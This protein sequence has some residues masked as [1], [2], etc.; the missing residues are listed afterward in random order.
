M[1]RCDYHT[2]T[3]LC[4]H[5][6]GEPEAFVQRALELGL[7]EYGIADHAPT[8][9]YYDDWRMLREELPAYISWVERA[10]A[11]A[12]GSD[13]RIRV[14]LECDWL[15]GCESWIEELSG[16]YNWDYLIGSIHYISTDDSF[17]NPIYSQ[18]ASIGKNN[19]EDWHNYWQ[20][21]GD[22]VKSGLFDF[23]GHLDIIKIWGHYPEGD[24]MPYYAPVLD[25]LQA[26][27][28]AVEL[29]VA[30]WLK[31][32]AEQ[33]P[34]EAFLAELLARKI[35]ICVNSDAHAPEQVSRLWEDGIALLQRLNGN[36]P[37][38]CSPMPTRNGSNIITFQGS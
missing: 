24:L 23:Y 2:H 12:A 26:D 13:L 11:A 35:P 34:S 14:G 31:P 17:D 9:H 19:A 18:R 3:P 32:C 27:D 6:E 30:G 4:H 10:K 16:L 28:G 38:L 36:K 25:A 1:H 21:A 33:Y 22:M 29:N 15:P 7:C 20:R 5:A 37:L 8:P